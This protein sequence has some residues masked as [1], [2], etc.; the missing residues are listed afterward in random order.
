MEGDDGRD[1]GVGLYTDGGDEGDGDTGG[2]DTDLC[3]EM[4]ERD[5]S[6]GYGGLA[7][8]RVEDRFLGL[9]LSG[10]CSGDQLLCIGGGDTG[11]SDLGSVLPTI[12]SI[13][14]PSLFFISL[15]KIFGGGTRPG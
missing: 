5:L 6:L 14:N 9:E 2:G 12:E 7:E 13:E 3:L 15:L 1:E 4:G 11:D 10:L 8:W